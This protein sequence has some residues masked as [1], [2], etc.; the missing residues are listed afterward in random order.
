MTNTYDC[1]GRPPNIL[2]NGVTPTLAY[3]R[4]N[5]LL[6]ESYVG[7]VLNGLA[8]TNVYDGLPQRT[9]N[10]ALNN[11]TVLAIARG[12]PGRSGRRAAMCRLLAV[13]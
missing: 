12:L 13:G 1:L 4:A 5:D 3:D 2:R 9:G 7:G 10:R 11:S 8:T 6:G